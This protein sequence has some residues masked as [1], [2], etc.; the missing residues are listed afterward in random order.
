MLRLDVTVGHEYVACYG[1]NNSKEGIK[2][3]TA[4]AGAK[5]FCIRPSFKRKKKT[6]PGAVF[7]IK[8]MDLFRLHQS[9]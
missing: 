1:M 6:A 7:L 5:E 9:E 8:V 4:W 3:I 2:F